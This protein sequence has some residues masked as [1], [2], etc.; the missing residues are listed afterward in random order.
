MGFAKSTWKASWKGHP[1][2][3]SSSGLTHG[4]EVDVAGK[5]AIKRAITMTG[6]GRWE[7]DVDVGGRSVHVAVE[8]LGSLND[9]DCQLWIDGEQIALEKVA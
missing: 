8:I 4:F 2:N 5:V 3:V 6:S 1:V 9:S 7:G